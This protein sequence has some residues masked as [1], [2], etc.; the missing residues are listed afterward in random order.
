MNGGIKKP[1]T[2]KLGD[3]F[4]CVSLLFMGAVILVCATAIAVAWIV[5]G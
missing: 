1:E 3:A 5:S 2:K 4:T